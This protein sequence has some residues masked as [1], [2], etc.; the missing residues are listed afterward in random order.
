MMGP[1]PGGGKHWVFPAFAKINGDR[2]TVESPAVIFG[3]GMIQGVELEYHAYS[4]FFSRCVRQDGVWKIYTFEVLWEHDT[5]RAARP[6]EKIPF[7]FAQLG[8][9]RPSYRHMAC[10]QAARGFTVNQN[11][12]GDDRPE[13]LKAFH[14]GEDAWLAGKG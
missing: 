4:R 1:P 5:M 2:A 10:L 9:M 3:R 8:A 6:G 13:E 11:L 7:D 12:L 14:E